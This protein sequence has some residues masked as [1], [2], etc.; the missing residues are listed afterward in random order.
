MLEGSRWAAK[1]SSNLGG[2]ERR[3]TLVTQ[4]GTMKALKK[5]SRVK[6]PTSKF[7]EVSENVK[8]WP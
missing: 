1:L 5:E 3:A 8:G 7:L 6:M 4:G 2:G